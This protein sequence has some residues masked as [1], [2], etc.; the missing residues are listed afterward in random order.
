[1]SDQKST[2]TQGEK[3]EMFRNFMFNELGVTKAD[4]RTWIREAVKEQCDAL[5]QQTFDKFDGPESYVS[6]EVSKRIENAFFEPGDMYH[7]HG[8][9]RYEIVHQL[10]NYITNECDEV[11][12]TA[13]KKEK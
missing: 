13:S 11:T 7:A 6:K 12:I 10:A 5:I 4:I 1:M 3:Y 9:L 2:M 8:K